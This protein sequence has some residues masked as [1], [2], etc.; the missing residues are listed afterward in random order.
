MRNKTLVSRKSWQMG[1]TD[2]C[3][4]P[5][6]HII[7][8]RGGRGE[9]G[10]ARRRLLHHCGRERVRDPVQE[11]GRGGA[12]GRGPRALRLLRGDRPD[13]GQAQGRHRHRRRAPEVREARQGEVR[14]GAGALLRHSEEEH[15][16]VQQL[17]VPVRLENARRR[18]LSDL[19]QRERDLLYLLCKR[20]WCSEYE[21]GVSLIL[22][23]SQSSR[24]WHRMK[25]WL[26]VWVWWTARKDVKFLLILTFRNYI[27][28]LQIMVLGKHLKIYLGV[29]PF[30]PKN[31]FL[32]KWKEW[33]FHRWKLNFEATY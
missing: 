25:S 6:G 30:S 22:R 17:C 2:S 10:R 27:I 15:S 7:R 31:K 33:G 4:R 1:K 5:G 32:L 26:I 8:G 24:V 28:L 16:P 3:W 14:E 18:H 13:A 12:G 23:S 19:L 20:Q 29:T 21:L 9:A 11:W